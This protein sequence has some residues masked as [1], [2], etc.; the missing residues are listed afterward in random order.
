MLPQFRFL[1]A[2]IVF[3]AWLQRKMLLKKILLAK[4]LAKQMKF[5]KNCFTSN[6]V[7]WGAK[8]FLT[9]SL[10]LSSM[11]VIV[12]VSFFDFNFNL[13]TGLCECILTIFHTNTMRALKRLC[14]NFV[15]F[16]LLQNF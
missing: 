5:N 9:L 13:S 4:S 16:K 12:R 10:S 6:I 8:I 11:C 2:F 15:L 7:F 1:P 3:K 14:D